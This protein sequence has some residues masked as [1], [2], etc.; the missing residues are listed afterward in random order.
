M[1]KFDSKMN[2][3]NFKYCSEC[4]TENELDSKFCY[5][6]GNDKF[7]DSIDEYKEIKNNKYCVV[8]NTYEPQTTV[9]YTDNSSFSL[10]LNPNEIKWYN[11]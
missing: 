4:G 1:G 5:E 8:N 2:K 6:C 3:S 11:I 9:V 7:F 10:D